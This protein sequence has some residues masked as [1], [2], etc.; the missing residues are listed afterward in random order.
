MVASKLSLIGLW[1]EMREM[2]RKGKVGRRKNEEKI[3]GMKMQK[4]KMG[5]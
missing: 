2:K 1:E 3:W 5:D 4:R